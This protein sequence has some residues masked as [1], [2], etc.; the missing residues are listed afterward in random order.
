M[1]IG[2]LGARGLLLSARKTNSTRFLSQRN[3]GC[4]QEQPIEQRIENKESVYV[5]VFTDKACNKR[6]FPWEKGRRKG[7]IPRG[8]SF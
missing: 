8:L 7:S 3:L 2:E 5:Q 6:A 4:D 1:E